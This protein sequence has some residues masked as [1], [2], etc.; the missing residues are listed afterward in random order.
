MV[1]RQRPKLQEI[2]KKVIADAQASGALPALV[3]AAGC[4]PLLLVVGLHCRWLYDAAAGCVM[5]QHAC[6]IGL[7][8]GD[9]G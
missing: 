8:D 9:L 7:L 3:S 1:Q 2:L 6:D 4:V 5:L